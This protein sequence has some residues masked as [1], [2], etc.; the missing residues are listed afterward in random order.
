M[1]EDDYA[2]AKTGGIEIAREAVFD[3]TIRQVRVIVMDRNT[4]LAGT[5][6]M[7]I[8]RNRGEQDRSLWSRLRNTIL[9]RSRDHRERLASL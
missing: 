4:N 7:P 6:T 3:E 9:P 8:E 2:R 1:S 5:V